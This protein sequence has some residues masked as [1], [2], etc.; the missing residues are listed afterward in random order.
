[1]RSTVRYRASDRAG[2]RRMRD[3]GLAVAQTDLRVNGYDRRGERIARWPMH[4]HM[5]SL[6]SKSRATGSRIIAR[7]TATLKQYGFRLLSYC[8]YDI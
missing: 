3:A 5:P 7:R 4:V 8:T 1:M 2:V 6:L